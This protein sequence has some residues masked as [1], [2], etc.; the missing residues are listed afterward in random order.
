MSHILYDLCE[1]DLLGLKSL[2][3]LFSVSFFYLF[4]KIVLNGPNTNYYS[5]THAFQLAFQTKQCLVNMFDIPNYQ[6]S[7]ECV[8]L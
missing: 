6:M 4:K 3:L 8:Q 2:N 1:Q 7:K 5:H